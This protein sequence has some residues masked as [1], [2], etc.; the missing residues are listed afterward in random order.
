MSFNAGRICRYC[1]ATHGD[2][3]RCFKESDFVLRTA[4]VYRYHLE[5][6]KENLDTK[7]IY[8]VTGG[9]PFDKLDYF[10]VT[11]SLPPD[12]MHDFLEGVVPLVLRLV[13]SKAHREKVIT[14]QEFNEE[15]R[16]LA[17]GQNDKKK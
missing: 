3:K 2:I 5:C 7:A 13:L 4:D 10:D 11:T 8:G 14:I 12:V 6:V 9:C 17:F 16:K 15:L 1:M